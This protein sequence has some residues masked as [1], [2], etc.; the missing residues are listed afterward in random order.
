M[1]A[2]F[3]HIDA[4][5]GAH[6]RLS[7]ADAVKHLGRGILEVSVVVTGGCSSMVESSLYF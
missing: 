2:S 1:V 5:T 4:S 6:G 3:P 7:A